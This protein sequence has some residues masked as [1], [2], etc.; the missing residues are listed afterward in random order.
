MPIPPARVDDDWQYLEPWVL[1]VVEATPYFTVHG[2][3]EAARSGAM[4]L[5]TAV[6]VVD[7]KV[8]GIVGTQ[9]VRQQT[10]HMICSGIFIMGEQLK[11]WAHLIGELEVWARNNGADRLSLWARK[12]LQKFYPDFKWTHVLLEKELADV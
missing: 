11:E 5:H 1:K 9:F 3:R 4:H 8:L 12:G 7:R 2:I 10:G 6:D